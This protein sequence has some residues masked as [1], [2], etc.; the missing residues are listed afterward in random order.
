VILAIV[1]SLA[2]LLLHLVNFNAKQARLLLRAARIPSIIVTNLFHVS[3]NRSWMI[4]VS[5]VVGFIGV[6]CS[7]NTQPLANSQ[8]SVVPVEALTVSPDLNHASLPANSSHLQH[9]PEL[10]HFLPIAQPNFVWSAQEASFTADLDVAY[11]EIVHWK[12]NSFAVPRGS[13]GKAFVH[14]L[15]CLFLA[16]GE[17]SAMS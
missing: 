6:L 14:E 11:Q 16:V 4:L 9:P 7:Q 2:L 8:P 17:G 13:S 5:I 12:K 1:S 15:A 3:W 10:P